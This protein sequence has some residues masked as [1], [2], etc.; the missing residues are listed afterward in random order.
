MKTQIEIA[1]EMLQ[2]EI[3]RIGVERVTLTSSRSHANELIELITELGG[4]IT[5]KCAAVVVYEARK[6]LGLE[7]STIAIKK[8]N[9]KFFNN[10]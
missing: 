4:K 6:E 8:A 1:V 7:M 10:K 9:N 5:K 2:E 3:R